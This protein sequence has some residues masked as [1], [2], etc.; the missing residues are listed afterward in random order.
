M[1]KEEK[2]I[3]LYGIDYDSL[4]KMLYRQGYVDRY[5]KHPDFNIRRVSN[6]LDELILLIYNPN[7]LTNQKVKEMLL[8]YVI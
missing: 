7:M 5:S 6:T 2:Q 3:H 1:I 8:E 4:T